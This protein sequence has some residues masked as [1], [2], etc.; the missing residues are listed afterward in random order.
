MFALLLCAIAAVVAIP[1]ARA[2]TDDAAAPVTLR[3]PL[4]V[5]LESGRGRINYGAGVVK[6]TGYGIAPASLLVSDPAKAQ[7]AALDDARAAA[8][9][10]L[11]RTVNAIQVTA[12]S[13]VQTY[14]AANDAIGTGIA[15]LLQ[16]APSV[17]ASS[18]PDGTA[19]VVVELPLYG[20][21]SIAGLIL[22]ALLPKES[23]AR[24]TSVTSPA[25]AATEAAAGGNSPSTPAGTSGPDASS[26]AVPGASASVT[27]GATDQTTGASPSA[28]DTTSDM[29]P[30]PVEPASL[31][32]TEPGNQD[33]ATPTP[34]SDPGPFTAVIVD[35]RGLNTAALLSP[36]IAD[37]AGR[38]IYGATRATPAFA[39]ETGIVGYPRS[40]AEA[41][42]SSRCG[43]H[44]LVVRAVRPPDAHGVDATVSVADGDRILAMDAHGHYLEATR[45][46]L[47]IGPAP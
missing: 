35:C 32:G 36:R 9:R 1:P 30:M 3:D 19:L 39:I 37:A 47:L 23:P 40:M 20:Q 4:V 21:N 15:A 41:L 34:A 10:T 8:L 2:A 16:S 31:G 22:P 27:T 13:Q 43:A 28:A 44:P 18:E 5:T 42:P 45:V 11:A 33:A 38:E 24:S 17:S 7:Q 25:S 29:P 12:T 6:A 14:A 26:A 46:M